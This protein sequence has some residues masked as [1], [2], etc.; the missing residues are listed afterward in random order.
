[1]G[2][3]KKRPCYEKNLKTS[4]EAVSHLSKIDPKQNG[5]PILSLLFGGRWTVGGQSENDFSLDV[6]RFLRHGRVNKERER[7]LGKL[8]IRR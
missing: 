1:M 6:A 3:R 2:L 7:V 4:R 5:S 8:E